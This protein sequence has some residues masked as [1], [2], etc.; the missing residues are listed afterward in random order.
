MGL[1]YCTSAVVSFVC[2]SGFT[3]AWGKFHGEMNVAV[4]L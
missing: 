3:Q 4:F 1:F 2:L